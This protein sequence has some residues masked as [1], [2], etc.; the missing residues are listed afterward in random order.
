[1]DSSGAICRVNQLQPRRFS[2]KSD[3]SST[4][5]DGFLAHEV[6]SIVPEA[7]SG[8][9]DDRQMICNVV[10]AADGTKITKNVSEEEWISGKSDTLYTLGD[11]LPD[12][13][14]IGDVKKAALYATDT[15]WEAEREVD[16][17]QSMDNAKLVPLLTAAIKELDAR[18]IVLEAS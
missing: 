3:A 11:E 2:W 4:L 12:G 1:M 18:V 5:W 9:K 6:D 10:A 17:Y 13:K 7:V 15:A 16:W 14:A 8:I